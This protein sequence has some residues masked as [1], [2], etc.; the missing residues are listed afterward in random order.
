MIVACIPAYNEERDLGPIV[1]KAAKFVD[2]I[3]VC[4]DGS[5]DLTSEIAKRL[6]CDLIVHEHRLGKGVALKTL[7]ER[8]IELKADIIVTLDGDGQ[9][10]PEDIPGIIEPILNGD[11]DIVVG[12]RFI[13][14]YNNVPTHRI[15]GNNVMTSFTR[16]LS[17]DVFK[18]LTDSQSGFRA[19]DKSILEDIKLKEKGM[20]VDSEILIAASKNKIKIKEVPI[21]VIYNGD[22]GSTFGPVHHGFDVFYSL[23]KIASDQK[24]ML[25]FGLP[26]VIL[27]I[28]GLF[29]SFRVLNIFYDIGEIAIGSAL[30]S[31]SL[32][33]IG[34]LSITTA[35]ILQVIQNNKNL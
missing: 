15:I 32:M 27:I 29:F 20:G 14:D 7:F 25:F 18:D 22:E 13:N 17:S 3:I 34:F 9:H 19:F 4:D 21:S 1:I 10:R 24:P 5:N 35:I 26:G 2:K 11:A 31:V 28:I 8:A 30:I 12:S 23:F 33:V 6:D 16:L